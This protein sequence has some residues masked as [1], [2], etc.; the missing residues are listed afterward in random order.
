MVSFQDFTAAFRFLD[1]PAG[2]PVIAHAAL[3]AFGQVE[4]GA[5][6]LLAALLEVYP[7]LLMPAFT[8]KTMLTPETGPADN[9]LTYG[10][11]ADANQMAEFFRPNMPVDRLIG[12][13]PEALRCY[14]QAQRSKHPIL[15]FTGIGAQEFLRAQTLQE[16]LG[17]IRLLL[18]A[19]GW[20][21]LLGVDYTVN[22]SIH[23]AER[24]AGRKQ[25]IRWALAP[26]GVVE[27]PGF[28]GCS[29]GF[30]ALA[31]RL[32]AVT[33]RAFV[34]LAY[35]Q[36]IPL[37]QLV[38]AA[39]EMLMDDPLALL[40]NDPYCERCEALRSAGSKDA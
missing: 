9:G 8:Y 22:T 27:C 18:E 3:S 20:V 15:S 28:P 33:R 11:R 35:I 12:K 39:R 21:V 36:A 10:A 7:R 5:P 37:A 30:Q 38:Q 14:P 17:P 1:L 31:P 32:L 26:R 19:Q 25:F 40:C 16:P 34:G 6:T 29:S 4:G 2:R 23:H 13:V 24:L